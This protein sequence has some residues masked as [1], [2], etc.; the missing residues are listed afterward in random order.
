MT[1]PLLELPDG[2]MKQ[3]CEKCADENFPNWN[4]EDI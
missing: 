3:C 4:D 2:T 1:T